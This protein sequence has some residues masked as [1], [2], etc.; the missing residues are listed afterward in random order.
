MRAEVID[1]DAVRAET[2]ACARLVHF[3]NAGA[4][5][6]PEP[7]YM[8]L[9]GYLADEREHGGYETA[10]ARSA[11]LDDFYAA[12]AQ[13]LNC[14]PDEVAFIENATRAWDMAFYSI[15]FKP[16]DRILTC[17]SEYVSNYISLLQV[18]RKTGAR[19]EVVP[20]DGSGQLDL[21]ALERMLK[22]GA[23]RLV[24]LTHVPTQGG[25]INPAAEVGRLA[26]A[27]GALY[28]LDACQSAGQLELDVQVLNCDFLSGTGRKFLRGPRGTGFLYARRSAMEKIEP[29]FL[30]LHAAEWIDGGS[31]SVREDARKFENWECFY[32]GKAALGTAMRYALSLGMPAIESRVLSLATTMR[33]RLASLPG[34][35]LRD[36]GLRKSGIV[37]L[38]KDGEEANALQKRLQAAR[39]NTSVSD[40]GSAR[41][42]FGRRGLASVLRVSV[43]YYNTEDEI[44]QLAH[45]LAS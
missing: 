42:D 27:Y 31:Y 22:Q 35:A 32:A 17:E 1:I 45:Q 36:I 39:I 43:H 38:T 18:A 20:S 21:E 33:E 40:A 8:R 3:N 28:L 10:R 25:L 14:A 16:G 11:D 9:I 44:E 4:A 30:D 12:T 7:V 23:V 24:A 6:M 13:L 26:A 5:L 19:L 2:P 15:D 41:L 37:T 29:V 34:I